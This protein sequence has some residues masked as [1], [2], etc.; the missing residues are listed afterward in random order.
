MKQSKPRRPYS[1]VLTSLYQVL[2]INTELEDPFW[3]SGDA[4]L[5]Q[6]PSRQIRLGVWNIFK[7]N[8]G[9][10]FLHDFREFVYGLDLV[11]IQEALVSPHSL[12]QYSDQGLQAV[13]CGSYERMDGLRDGVMTL[14]RWAP[15]GHPERVPSL[16]P[17]PVFKTPKTALI[18][19]YE[20]PHCTEQL[21]VV[22]LHATL[23]RGMNRLQEEIDQ[24]VCAIGGHQGPLI[25][26]GDF[27]TFRSVYFRRMEDLFADIGLRHVS[28]RQDPRRRSFEKLDH[29]FARGFIVDRV[30]VVHKIQ[31]S[32]HF[33]L[34]AVLVY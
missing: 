15:I 19:R 13:H 33:P 32:D 31:S 3:Q 26:A 5:S 28:I 30:K 21:L 9:L 2:K 23:M 18:T 17:E 10:R 34:Q 29:I 8:G 24:I 14:S 1:K 20:L 27:N 4:E 11:L 6:L 16:Y 25:V 22:N 7:G 12:E